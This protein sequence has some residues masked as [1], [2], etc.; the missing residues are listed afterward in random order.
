MNRK[1]LAICAAMLLVGGCTAVVAPPDGAEELD[2]DLRALLAEHEVEAISKPAAEEAKVRLGQALFFDKLLSGNRNIS[3]ATCHTPLAF[4]GDGLSLSVGQGG[5]GLAQGRAAPVDQGGEPIF[6]PRNAPEVFNRAG[7]TTMF[8]DGRVADRGDGTFESP[9]GDALLP[10]LESAL[11]VQAMFPVT[12]PDEM[13]GAAGENEIADADDDDFSGIWSALM[14]RV[15]EFDEYRQL[16]AAA[17]PDVAEHDL[18]FAHAA[19]AIAAFEIE[20]WTLVDSPFDAYLRGDGT[21][22]SDSAKR[23]AV[24]F[25]GKA[26]C[27]NC[28]TGS[29]MT[30]EDYHNRAVPQLGPG[31]GDGDAGLADFGRERVTEDQADRCK[32]RTPPLRNVAATGP[33]MHDGAFTTLEAAVRHQL[34]CVSS[35]AAFDAEQLSAALEPLYHPE[36]TDTILAAVDPDETE[37]VT[38]TAGEFDDLMQFMEAL[39]S[40]SLGWLAIADTPDG[41]PS[42]LPLAD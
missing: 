26:G 37:P 3:C 14:V 29:L 31:K 32:F 1:K 17:Y 16:F 28:H 23:G 39:T 13:R 2:T 34:D 38:L 5:T 25:Y 19:N 4:T 18:T 12:S 10:G 24:L 21:A 35:V 15:L 22:L 6:I 41:V 40:P 8:W 36:Q 30:D 20:H 42:G 7:F 33:W 9:A 27:A 11:A